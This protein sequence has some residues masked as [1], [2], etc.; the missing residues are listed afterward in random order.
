MEPDGTAV[1]RAAAARRIVEEVAAR[2]AFYEAVGIVDG[3]VGGGDPTS[4]DERFSV[5]Y[6]DAHCRAEAARMAAIVDAVADGR[7]DPEWDGR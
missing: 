3:G 4:A 7:A 2:G 1:D 6:D 5:R